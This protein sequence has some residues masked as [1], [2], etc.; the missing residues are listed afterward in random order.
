[1]STK[2]KS[3]MKNARKNATKSG[4]TGNGGGRGRGRG[5]ARK[6]FDLNDSELDNGEVM[7][8]VCRLFIEGKKVSEIAKVLEDTYP[9]AGKV[10]REKPY[11]ILSEAA[12]CGWLRYHPPIHLA[13]GEEIRKRYPWLKGVAVAHT[14][15]PVD[16]A[17]EAA[18]MLR[19]LVQERHRENRSKNEVHIGFAAG[20]SMQQLAQ[21]FADLLCEPAKDLPE[22]IVFHA[23]VTGYDPGDPTTDPNTF[24]LFFNNHPVLHIE[25]KFVSLH[26]PTMLGPKAIK[27]LRKHP[28][29]RRA[30]D[31]VDDLDIIATSGADWEDEHSS[32]QRCMER[33]PRSLGLL[34]KEGAI[35]DLCWRPMGADGPIEVE[36]DIR[37]MTLIQLSSLPKL[38]REGKRVL[39]TLGPCCICNRPKG[40]V[41]STVLDLPENLV[42]HV[43]VD[44]RS[45]RYLVG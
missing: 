22:R 7:S 38:I 9:Q 29:I 12:A 27:E 5:K 4:S 24:F 44:S 14:T 43:V 42:T 18:L 21:E 33:S 39:M 36:T 8:L 16:V 6:K 28:D 26:A 15:V 3:S 1:M 10:S 20:F 32:L 23:L 31:G 19:G 34:K 35:I 45:A 30:Y 2:L 37:A 41:L 17:S 11:A 25:P 13:L 40:R